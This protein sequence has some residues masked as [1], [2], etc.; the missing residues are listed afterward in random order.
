MSTIKVS[1]F[2]TEKIEGKTKVI[3]EQEFT[4]MSELAEAISKEDWSQSIFKDSYRK[5]E[6]FL[7]ADVVALDFDDGLGIIQ[8]KEIFKDYEHIIIPTRSHLKEKNGQPA[9]DRF[10]VVLRLS[11][12]ITDGK[13]FEQVMKNLLAQ[14]PQADQA[15]KDPG[16][17]WAAGGHAY[18]TVRDDGLKIDVDFYKGS[19]HTRSSKKATSLKSAQLFKRYSSVIPSLRDET[20][21]FL[22]FGA[23]D[24]SFNNAL[25]KSAYDCRDR[26]IT[27]EDFIVMAGDASNLGSLDQQDLASVK[28][29]Y[30]KGTPHIAQKRNLMIAS[31]MNDIMVE[32][33]EDSSRCVLFNE[34]NDTFTTVDKASV[35]NMMGSSRFNNSYYSEKGHCAHFVYRP[36]HIGERLFEDSGRL[37]FNQYKEPKW[38]KMSQ[39]VSGLPDIYRLFFE[40]LTA[41]DTASYEYLLD[42][43]ANSLQSRNQTILV[44]IGEEGIGKGVLAQIMKS[45]HGENNFIETTDIIFKKEF[46]A[47]LANKTLVHIDELNIKDNLTAL[48]RLKAIVNPFIQIEEKGKNPFV[49]EN[50]ASY[51]ICSNNY[52]A[53][54]LDKGQR[55]FSVIQ[56]TDEKLCDSKLVKDVYSGDQQELIDS[57]L[58]EENIAKLGHYLLARQLDQKAMI[59]PFES[60]RTRL[61]R[62]KSLKPWEEWLLFDWCPRQFNK[63][64]NNMFEYESEVK[65]VI[66]LNCPY[67]KS[68]PGRDKLEDLARRFPGIFSVHRNNNKRYIKILT[69]RP[70]RYNDG[71]CKLEI[72][73]SA[74]SS[75]I[76]NGQIL[77]MNF[78]EELADTATGN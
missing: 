7:S 37:Y 12:R 75:G 13:E 1:F 27:E 44:A 68:A 49:A 28:S 15:P 5:N 24:G 45:L 66:M 57:L 69:D 56:L 47:P 8:A 4:K 19:P 53:L 18:A 76:T 29:I 2:G 78:S 77:E 30:A 3:S 73:H 34:S 10:R 11:R 70:I 20:I 67:M 52:D 9:V 6:N 35:R 48:N 64:L 40:N 16:R 71:N 38:A 41:G 31:M 33:I 62:E 39:K 74:D 54:P 26:G 46:N 25:T 17:K 72:V 32:A 59:R 55:R 23:P 61:I 43:L 42:W 14:Y 22:R 51:Y 21:D 36:H 60:E 65:P 63:R 50:H 58:E